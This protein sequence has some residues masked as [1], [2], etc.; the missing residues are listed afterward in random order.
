VG[1]SHPVGSDGLH[2]LRGYVR[3][4]DLFKEQAGRRFLQLPETKPAIR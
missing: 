4:M 1:K 2:T 3:R